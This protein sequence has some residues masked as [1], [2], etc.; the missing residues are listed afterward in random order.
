M[1]GEISEFTSSSNNGCRWWFYTTPEK[2]FI[3]PWPFSNNVSYVRGQLEVGDNTGY[4]HYQCVA[5][6]TKKV[7]RATARLLF[8]GVGDCSSVRNLDRALDYV[9]KAETSVEGTQF[10]LGSR[11]VRRQSKRD[12]ESVWEQARTGDLSAIDKSILVPHYSNIKRICAD[13]MTPPVRENVKLFIYWGVTG[14]GKSLRAYQEAL[15]LEG[16]FF[17]KKDTK[18]WCGYRGQKC[19]IFDEFSGEMPLPEILSIINWMPHTVE[20]KGGSVS[21]EATHF[22]FTSNTRPERWWPHANERTWD[23]FKRRITVIEEFTSRYEE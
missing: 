1:N 8:G 7:R 19:V 16:E 4:R 23:A 14:A 18:W 9:H 6:F 17:K 10:E 21:L 5:H 11:P 3:M 13:N 2:D 12:W 22:W 15:A 20:V